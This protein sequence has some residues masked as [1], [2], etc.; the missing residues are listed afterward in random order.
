MD[1]KTSL[2]R[3]YAFIIASSIVAASVVIYLEWLAVIDKARTELIYTNNV[4]ASSVQSSFRHHEGLLKILG[5]RLVELDAL[6]TASTQSKRLVDELLQNNPELAGFGLAAPSGQLVLTSFNIDRSLLPNL[7]KA[8]TS[9][10]TFKQALKNDHMILGH[11]YFM[12]AL[13]QWIIPLRYRILDKS[14]KVAAVMTTGLKLDMANNLWADMSLPND[15]Q[16]QIIRKDFYR[17]YADVS[18]FSS[19]EDIYGDAIPKQDSNEFKRIIKKDTGQNLD[20]LHLSGEVFTIKGKIGKERLPVLY[21]IGYNPRY[22]IYTLLAR[23]YKSLYAE[24]YFPIVLISVLLSLYLGLLYWV[25]NSIDKIQLASKQKLKFQAT[26]DSLTLLPNRRYLLNKFDSWQQAHN[27]Q[28]YMIF[29]DLNNFKSSND[30]YGH[31]IGDLIL[32]EVAQRIKRCFDNSLKIRQGGDEFIILCPKSESH[33]IQERCDEFLDEL[34][35]PIVVG[36]LD[37]TIGASIGVSQSPI[38]GNNVDELQR[39]ADM[40]MYQAKRG[41]SSVAVFSE[42]LGQEQKRKATIEKELTHALEKNEFY[43][44]YQPQVDAKSNKIVGVEVLIRWENEKLGF[45][46]PEE[47]IFIA[48]TTGL[49]I[50]IGEVVLE[51]SLNE[52]SQICQDI[53]VDRP[54]NLSINI[55]VYQLLNSGFIAYLKEVLKQSKNNCIDVTLEMTENLFIEDM[56]QARLILDD[57]K[58]L[59][60]DISL[61]DF[62]TGYSSLSVLTNLPISELK[63]DKSFVRDILVDKNDRNLIQSIINLSKGLNIPVLAEGVEEKEQADLLLKFGCDLFQGYYF[64]KPLSKEDLRSYIIKNA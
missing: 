56:V 16:V 34:K 40:A 14:G 64:A 22:E 32:V 61:D 35:R 33:N 47:F 45:V 19:M 25:F 13:R 43:L 10:V 38:D 29:I 46:S 30:L 57:I 24:L 5:E 63:I 42:Q 26:H 17:L 48:E 36:D 21:S 9:A 41:G 44:V 3:T 62:G 18:R 20:D 2:W 8:P 39:K 37:F 1:S 27:G 52:F 51:T 28:F 15:I 59:G 31:T 58:A 54:L 49:I 7:L 11:V 55:S 23:P 53:K 60:V 50:D 6:N 4:M 12:K